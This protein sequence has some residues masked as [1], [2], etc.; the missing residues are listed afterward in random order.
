MTKWTPTDPAVKLAA[1][2]P[3]IKLSAPL[4]RRIREI[5]REE[6][7]AA[8]ATIKADLAHPKWDDDTGG[9]GTPTR[10]FD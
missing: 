10:P 1:T 6:I 2:D 3:A 5:V 4:E 7:D 9:G 8:V